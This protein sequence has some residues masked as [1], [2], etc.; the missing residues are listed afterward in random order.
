MAGNPNSS[1]TLLARSVS[2]F[3]NNG[4]PPAINCLRKFKNPPSCLVIFLVIP[5]NKI[6]LFSKH[7]ATFI[8]SFISLFVR[9][10]PEHL[11]VI[12]SLLNLSI[13]L[14]RKLF[15]KF[16]AISVPF[17]ATLDKIFP[18]IGMLQITPPNYTILT[19]CV[20]E[21]FISAD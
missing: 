17:F 16:L 1:K 12:Y 2:T 13:C 14:S 11:P 10:V 18:K 21:N 8:I 15:P 7:L 5:L 6:P 9:V 4:K 20:F 19:N 3:F